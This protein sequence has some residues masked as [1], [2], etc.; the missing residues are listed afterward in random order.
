M[1]FV[2]MTQEKKTMSDSDISVSVLMSQTRHK[3]NWAGDSH[4]VGIF[5]PDSFDGMVFIFTRTF[6]ME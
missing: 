4:E 5:A 3:N 6:L 1:H 2:C